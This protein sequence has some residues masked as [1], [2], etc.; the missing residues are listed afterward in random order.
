MKRIILLLTLL[1]LLHGCKKEEPSYLY[2]QNKNKTAKS[3]KP[4]YK[5]LQGVNIGPIDKYG[6]IEDIYYFNEKLLML[7][8]KA[9]T[10][11]IKYGLKNKEIK[12]SITKGEGPNQIQDSQFIRIT[13]FNNFEDD[14]QIYNFN[15]GLLQLN[16][17]KQNFTYLFKL[18]NQDYRSTIQSIIKIRD[19]I[20]AYTSLDGS[21]EFVIYNEKLKTKKEV[22]TLKDLDIDYNSKTL[23]EITAVNI[24]FNANNNIIYTSNNILN[25]INLF[26]EKGEYIKKISFGKNKNIVEKRLKRN[27][28]YYYNVKSQDDFLY[29]LYTGTTPLDQFKQNLISHIK[30]QLHIFN[31]KTD[32]MKVYQLDRLVSCAT[33]DFDNK[34]IYAIDEDNESQPLVKYEMD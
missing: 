14:I 20:Y 18:Q 12:K 4:T 6:L 19:S 30:T 5:K 10:I 34:V 28:F 8:T 25:S 2:I 9:D 15:K 26:N 13:N 23:Q 1:F 11:F 22:P 17:E 31:L 3:V 27:Y 21:N 29:A 32:Q 24:G 7:D 16:F 33:I